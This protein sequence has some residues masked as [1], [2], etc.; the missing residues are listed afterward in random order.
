MAAAPDS[1]VHDGGRWSRL[2]RVVK[3][4]PLMAVVSVLG[5]IATF[6]VGTTRVAGLVIGGG[7]AGIGPPIPI[8]ETALPVTPAYEY[9][10]VSDQTGQI[11][12]EVPT[13][14]GNVLG[15]GWHASRGLEPIPAGERV[16]PGLNASPSVEAWRSDL[17][18]P[19]VFVGASRSVLD[20]FTPRT[21][22]QRVSYGACRT[23]GSESYSTDDF[24][25]EIVT[26]TCPGGTQWRVLAAVPTAAREYL[27]YLQ[28]KLVSTRDVEAYNRVL[29]T[30]RV[31]L[32]A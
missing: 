24:T 8:D 22:L 9:V 14:W 27:V 13:E 15:N 10:A 29:D 3:S 28:V 6:V 4:H 23:A 2:A 5:T 7:T 21:I 32:G 1:G 19:G 26:W 25:G 31:D 12:V 16:G 11:S 17:L 20:E 30:F 18:T